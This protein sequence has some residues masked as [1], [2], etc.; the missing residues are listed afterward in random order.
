MDRHCAQ[1]RRAR[2]QLEMSV[3]AWHP[4]ARRGLRIPAV[5]V[6]TLSQDDPAG[7][8]SHARKSPVHSQHWS[9]RHWRTS[10]CSMQL[11]P[12]LSLRYKCPQ[13]S[14]ERSAGVGLEQLQGLEKTVSG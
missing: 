8:Q 1:G 4:Y 14:C 5:G 10:K 2:P 6:Q 11:S 12:S 3:A 9:A 7:A 13:C